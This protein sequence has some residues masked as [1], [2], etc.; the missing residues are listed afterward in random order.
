MQCACAA[1]AARG[2]ES[3]HMIVA[4]TVHDVVIVKV[5]APNIPAEGPLRL[6]SP[7]VE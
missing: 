3:I 7:H 5:V 2:K 1:V 6:V 4:G